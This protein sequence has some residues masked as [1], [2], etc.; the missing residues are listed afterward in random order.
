M[1]AYHASRVTSA[2]SGKTSYLVAGAEPGEKKVQKAQELKVKIIDEDAFL[3][4]IRTRPGKA[5]EVRRES[6]AAVGIAKKL[7]GFLLV[8]LSA[9]VRSRPR[10]PTTLRR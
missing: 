10:A 1:C 4:L 6:E 9:S 3:E 8:V 5:T 2:V 7:T